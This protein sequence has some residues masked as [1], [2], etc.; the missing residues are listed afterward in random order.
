MAPYADRINK[1]KQTT[2][3][4]AAN[5]RATQVVNQ[6]TTDLDAQRAVKEL[7]NIQST[8]GV[9]MTSSYQKIILKAGQEKSD[10]LSSLLQATQNFMANNPGM[11]Q[12]QAFQKAVESGA[13]VVYSPEQLAT[14]NASDLFNQAIKDK[15]ATNPNIT[16]NPTQEGAQF[17]KPNFIEGN[18][19]K[20]PNN[21]TG[22]LYQ[23]GQLRPL[24]GNFSADEFKRATGLNFSD[25]IELPSFGSATVGANLTKESLLGST[26]S[27]TPTTP[28]SSPAPSTPTPQPTAPAPTTRAAVNTIV[29][30]RISKVDNKTLEYYRTDT[31][32][33][34][35]QPADLFDYLSS[36]GYGDLNSFGALDPYF[37]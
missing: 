17:A 5:V 23:N 31:G 20:L 37:K 19:Y 25:M 4:Q 29:G 35:S 13:G 33:G 27:Y 7:S 34:F 11:S 22:Y 32:A 1:D 14:K 8:Y 28:S 15:G 30:R 10:Q 16:V 6:F 2:L 36:K 21:P 9:D 24:A 26:P 12:E 3:D 18:V